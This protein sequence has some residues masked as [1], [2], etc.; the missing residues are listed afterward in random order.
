M[1]VIHKH[2][3]ARQAH[4]ERACL[5]SLCRNSCW[6]SA[7]A[8]SSFSQYTAFGRRL[9]DQR[10]MRASSLYDQRHMSN[11]PGI[12]YTMSKEEVFLLDMDDTVHLVKV[13]AGTW[14]C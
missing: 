7:P 2:K 1:K 5:A 12:N 11:W 13:P 4:Y 8:Q 3:L 6:A 14:R 9:Y 10:H